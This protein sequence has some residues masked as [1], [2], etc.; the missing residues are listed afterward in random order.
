[1]G[2]R[3][4]SVTADKSTAGR[5]DLNGVN[6][7]T[8][9]NVA[10]ARLVAA[11]PGLLEALKLIAAMDGDQPARSDWDMVHIARAAIAKA[12]GAA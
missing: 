10:D 8:E 5:W 4:I 3:S 6:V 9:Q 1:M 12:T 11:A 7:L 2:P